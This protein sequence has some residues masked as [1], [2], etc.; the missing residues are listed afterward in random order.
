[1]DNLRFVGHTGEITNLRRLPAKSM[2]VFDA[3][4]VLTLLRLVRQGGRTPPKYGTLLLVSRAR[5][6]LQWKQREKFLPVDPVFGVME[7]T[8]QDLAEDYAAYFDYIHSFFA[9]IYQV[10]DCDPAWFRWVYEAALEHLQ[11]THHS[12]DLTIRKIL[13]LAP[14]S[15]SIKN[16]DILRKVDEFLSWVIER[17]EELTMIGGPLLQL[18]V[19]AVAGEPGAHRFLK[20]ARVAKDGAA[21][22]ARN[23][24][25]DLL[26][27]INLEMHYH[28]RKYESTI[29][30]TAD[31]ALADFLQLRRNLSPR[32]GRAAAEASR[33]V[34]SFGTQKL[35]ALSKIDETRLG[36][37]IAQR[38]IAFWR[39][40][41][42]VS[43]DDIRFGSLPSLASDER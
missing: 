38:L 26:H 28:R 10:R 25:W 16:A 19:Y 31:Q 13:S 32:I 41:A 29:V 40:L 33:V 3:N 17:H 30:C 42:V 39:Q 18:A 4:T 43:K 11:F 7:L 9:T 24:A 21:M 35:P 36:L 37:E 22:V 8:K 1:M 2:F 5:V 14:A 34:E 23:V 12:V 27:W 6:H 15:G 20:L